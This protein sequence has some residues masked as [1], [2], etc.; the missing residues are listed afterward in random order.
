MG[1]F[2]SAWAQLGAVG[3]VAVF[4][5]ALLTGRLVPRSTAKLM[6]DQANENA[7]RWR[8]AAEASDERADLAVRQTGELLQAVRA[9]EALLRRVPAGGRD[10]A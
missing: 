2:D 9:V 4:V 3:I 1:L 5:L 10:V 7:T 8:A 6:V